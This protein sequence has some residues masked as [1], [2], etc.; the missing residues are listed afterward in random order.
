MFVKA[1]GANLEADIELSEIVS[2]YV[3]K[4]PNLD[5][6]AVGINLR[7]YLKVASEDLGSKNYLL[8]NFFVPGSWQDCGT[9]PVKAGLNLQFTFSS[10]RLNL[11]I[12]DA[13]LQLPNSEEIPIALFSG[14][15]DYELNQDTPS[16]RLTQLKEIVKNWPFDRDTYTQVVNQFINNSTEIVF[17]VPALV[18]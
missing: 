8:K 15:F 17:P 5:Y 6:Q 7:G 10:K 13:V 9:E 18:G 16:E 2:H 12:N 1:L 11:S 4:L 3:E 14:N